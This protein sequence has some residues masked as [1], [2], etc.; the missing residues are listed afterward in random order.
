M[1]TT[2]SFNG[3]SYT[4]PSKGDVDWDAT[5]NAFLRA[6]AGAA[7]ASGTVAV[8]IT[9]AT[10]RALTVQGDLTS[11]ALAALRIVPQDTQPSGPNLVGDTYLTAAGVWKTCIVAGSPGTWQSIGAQT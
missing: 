2:V 4:I 1:S 5:L 7:A 8:T 10:G 9:V 6:L 3:T 11:P